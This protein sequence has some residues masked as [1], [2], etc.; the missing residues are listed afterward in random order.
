[1]LFSELLGAATVRDGV[2]SAVVPDDWMQ[3]RSVFGGLQSAMALCA[4]RRL[5]APDLPL[6]VLQTTFVAP[7]PAGEVAIR[8]RVLRTGK[9]VTH[10][11]ASV[12]DG[13]SPAAL[14][15]GVFGRG[16]PS[17][18][19]VVPRLPVVSSEA[20]P[21][22]PEGARPPG[23]AFA[24]HFPMRWLRGD[25]PMTRSRRTDA[26]IEVGMVD[27]AKV[28]TEE[29]VVAIADAIPP[30]ALS[31]LEARAF[32][33]SVTWTLEMLEGGLRD[34]PLAGWQ[35]HVD[36]T[37]AKDGYTSQSVVVCGPGGGAVAL[38]RQSMVVFG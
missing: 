16:R 20:A 5:I 9:S 33:S 28:T 18:V 11:E 38:S 32:G 30:L 37:A 12:L 14:F 34:L 8:A 2:W 17:Q 35:L 23:V 7:V 13:A 1:M 10:V 4:M 24:A 25:L 29:H 21:P 36:L 31:F 27:S 26:V 15:V 6:R 19:E 3:G 22:R